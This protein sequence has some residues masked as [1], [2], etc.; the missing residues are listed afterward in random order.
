MESFP[1][2]FPRKICVMLIDKEEIE[3]DRKIK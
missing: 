1:F 3:F 2:F